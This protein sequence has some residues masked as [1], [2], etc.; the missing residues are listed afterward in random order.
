MNAPQPGSYADLIRAAMRHLDISIRDLARKKPAGTGYSYEHLRKICSGQPAHS[1]DCN[2]EIARVLKLDE[3][4]LWTVA[5]REKIRRS[6]PGEDV[7]QLVA[8][9]DQR[10][11]KVWARL[12]PEHQVQLAVMAE[13]LVAQQELTA[14][15]TK[16]SIIAQI[17]MLTQELAGFE[18]TA[19]GRQ[20]KRRAR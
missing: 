6:Y 3:A 15:R 14:P 8:P 5:T 20:E 1:E 9:D 17:G 18:A 12:T 16:E 7:A 19:A 13:G 11:R 4:E 10:M 2:H